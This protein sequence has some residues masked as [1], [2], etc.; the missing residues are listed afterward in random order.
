MASFLSDIGPGRDAYAHI[1]L[2]LQLEGI[3]NLALF[4]LE[5]VASTLSTNLGAVI[6]KDASKRPETVP[7]MPMAGRHST[8]ACKDY[9]GRQYIVI[10]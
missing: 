5:N 8:T 4:S 1:V 3:Q 9:V 6:A 10:T 7:S 2:V